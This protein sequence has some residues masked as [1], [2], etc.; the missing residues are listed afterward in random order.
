MFHIHTKFLVMV[1][2]HWSSISYF[3]GV[4]FLMQMC[5]ASSKKE[6]SKI[7]LSFLPSLKTKSRRVKCKSWKKHFSQYGN[8]ATQ[9]FLSYLRTIFS[10]LFR[11]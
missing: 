8:A 5:K 2:V 10:I 7:R 4:K 9:L 6:S 3:M 11:F 1:E